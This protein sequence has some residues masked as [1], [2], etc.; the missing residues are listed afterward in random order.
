MSVLSFVHEYELTPSVF[1]VSNTI[2]SEISSL[3][4]TKSE[5]N[6]TWA[7]GLTVIVNDSELP[8]LLTPPL[9]NVG[10]TTIF[11]VWATSN[12]FNTVNS[13]IVP[14]PDAANPI[15]VLSFI[16]V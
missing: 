13:D 4:Y 5:I 8:V 3:Q 12:E 15:D 10:V 14:V 1:I 6:S 7:V 2:S 16:Q 11:A 9:S